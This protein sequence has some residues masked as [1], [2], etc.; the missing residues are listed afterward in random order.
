MAYFRKE[1]SCF[2]CLFGQ[3]LINVVCISDVFEKDDQM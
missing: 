1:K 2:Y 3:E